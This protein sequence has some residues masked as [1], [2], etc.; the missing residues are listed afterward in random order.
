MTEKVLYKRMKNIGI[1]SCIL[2]SALG[3]MAGPGVADSLTFI[4]EFNSMGESDLGHFVESIPDFTG[5]G[6]TEMMVGQPY[7]NSNGGAV[8]IFF[9]PLEGKNVTTDTADITITGDE[10]GQKFGYSGAYLPD[11]FNDGNNIHGEIAIGA[12]GDETDDGAVYVFELD[13][14]D[15]GGAFTY[16]NADHTIT[17]DADEEFGYSLAPAADINNDNNPDLLIGAPSGFAWMDQ[18]QTIRSGRTYIIYGQDDVPGDSSGSDVIIKA[19]DS[20]EKFGFSVSSAGDLDNDGEN[21]IVAGAPFNGTTGISCIFFGGSLTGTINTASSDAVITGQSPGAELG[22]SASV[23]GDFNSDNI[24][25][26]LLGSPGHVSNW[27]AAY[28]IFG[29][30]GLGDM[31]LGTA[32]SG[33]VGFIA[34]RWARFG[35]SV[36]GL[37]DMDADGID[38]CIIGAPMEN[39]TRGFAYTFF[40]N[41]T[42]DERYIETTSANTTNRGKA[43]G[44]K[45]GTSVSEGGDVN[46]D[47]Y[48]DAFCGAGNASEGWG[49]A[50]VLKI[51]H[52][53]ALTVPEPVSPAKG[54]STTSFTYKVIYS[55]L[56]NDAPAT[57]FPRVAIYK[58]FDAFT[59]NASSPA[60]MELDMDSAAGLH[61][62]DYINGEQYRYSTVLGSDE[63]FNYRFQAR[64]ATGLLDDVETPLQ[65]NESMGPD[66]YVDVTPPALISNV[67]AVDTPS[68]YGG[69]ITVSW[70][71]S[72]T[73]DFGAYE[74]FIENTTF[75]NVQFKSPIAILFDNTT[76]AYDITSYNGLPLEDYTTYFVAVGAR[77]DVDNRILVPEVFEVIPKDNYNLFPSPISDLIAE[78][79]D[80]LGSVVLTWSAVGE[81]E[82]SDGPVGEYI[83]KRTTTR[84]FYGP[85]DWASGIL[86]DHDLTP[87][88]PGVEMGLTIEGLNHEMEH[89]F[90]VRAVDSVGQI[91]NL[92]EGARNSTTPGQA[93]DLDAPEPVLGVGTYNIENDNVS[94]GILWSKNNA[95]DFNHYNIYISVSHFEWINE[96]GVYLESSNITDKEIEQTT[97]S[98]INGQSLEFGRTYYAA[99]TAVDNNGNEDL[100]VICSSGILFTDD[101]DLTPPL[102]LENVVLSDTDGDNGRSLNLEWDR[103][104]VGD[105]KE[106]RIYVSSSNF[107]SLAD[108]SVKKT[109][110]FDD[111]KI[112]STNITAYEGT[113]LENGQD[114]YAA[115]VAVDF[116]GL[117]SPLGATSIAGPVQPVDDSDTD[118]PEAV[119]GVKAAQVNKINLTLEWTPISIGEVPDF[120]QYI[121]FYSSSSFGSDV[122][123]A[124]MMDGTSNANLMKHG[125]HSLF[126]DGLDKETSYYFAVLCQDDRM[127]KE[128][129][130]DG[131]LSNEVKATTLGDNAAPVLSMGTVSPAKGTQDNNFVFKV[132]LTD[133]DSPPLYVRLV[134]DGDQEFDMVLDTGN[135]T[136][137]AQ[138]TLSKR[139]SLGDHTYFFIVLDSYVLGNADKEVVH[140]PTNNIIKVSKSTT[141]SDG[142][143]VSAVAIIIIILVVLLITAAVFGLVILMKKRKK[144]EEEREERLIKKEKAKEDL[145]KWTCSCGEESVPVTD[146]GHC[147]F[148]GD[149]WDAVSIEE[150]KLMLIPEE[151]RMAQE[152]KAALDLYG[153]LYSDTGSTS[154][155]DTYSDTQSI[156]QSS[157]KGSMEN[158]DEGVG[159]GEVITETDSGAQGSA[160]QSPP[161]KPKPP[162]PPQ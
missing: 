52:I 35:E 122:A 152:K 139:L 36:S 89:Y 82:M 83:I 64:A 76:T 87:P 146:N 131:I 151:E 125:T 147:G 95:Q 27:G 3:L 26:V 31:D 149:T 86:V 54:N 57:G 5:D 91:S 71:E 17:G 94:I 138:Y 120:H 107:A 112:Q 142:G 113:S 20:D 49:R 145:P 97:I 6:L 22:F 7:N 43:R 141:G 100:S 109:L 40:G 21:D 44:E 48:L 13:N 34:T 25:D 42:F 41:E 137:G 12:P 158:F 29:D 11:L 62:G 118:E 16:A 108:A 38:D 78:P 39:E 61:D 75:S 129:D 157:D 24:D 10:M 60:P 135:Y 55:D 155:A 133:P 104:Y 130:V 136:T 68:D 106:Y 93:A 140:T 28:V 105:F 8:Y 32:Q 56:E 127:A 154:A 153:D 2:I 162:A 65:T 50:Y 67:V 37:G 126:I 23:A 116:N 72:S 30:A 19:F 9:S 47:V 134:L 156:E 63:D 132:H 74:I 51:N 85:S 18:G 15:Q 161:A 121:I 102:P 45:F 143:G 69:S 4:G 115:V 150:A 114:Y 73:A 80:D 1:I 96:T 101:N 90:A 123:S 79:G 144:E 160:Q 119:S 124:T 59:H 117:E 159:T 84:P 81:N 99:V 110:T 14:I 128:N 33:F 53:P 77:D 70:D 66:P 111:I 148:C 103:S 92:T 98:T 58:N 88:A 46:G